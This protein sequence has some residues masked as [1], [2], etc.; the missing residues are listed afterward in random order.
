[1]DVPIRLKASNTLKQ[2]Y[3]VTTEFEAPAYYHLEASL[4]AHDQAL[5]LDL[6]LSTKASR[7]RDYGLSRF[8]RAY[9]HD[10]DQLLYRSS[11]L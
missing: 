7:S 3:P 5:D 10:H 6:F 8:R 4:Q 1:M 9:H 2:V 11:S